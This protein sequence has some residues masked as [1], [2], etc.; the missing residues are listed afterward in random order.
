DRFTRN[1]PKLWQ[2]LGGRHRTLFRQF[3]GNEFLAQDR[4]TDLLAEGLRQFSGIEWR[5]LPDPRIRLWQTVA[6]TDRSGKEVSA[7]VERV[8]HTPRATVVSGT[9]YLA[10]ETQ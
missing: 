2:R 9:D 1:R 8:E 5:S 6:G 4:A 3:S 10:E 7:L